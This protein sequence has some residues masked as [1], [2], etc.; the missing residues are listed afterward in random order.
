[1]GFVGLT[2]LLVLATLQDGTSKDPVRGLVKALGSDSIQ[3]R[4]FAA[5]MLRALGAK[6]LP[7]LREGLKDADP[8][9]KGRAKALLGEIE[10]GVLAD[11]RRNKWLDEIAPSLKR[12]SLRF[13]GVSHVEAVRK[14]FGPFGVRAEVNE[15]AGDLGISTVSLRLEKASFWEAFDA[16]CD[17]G[18]VRVHSIHFPFPNYPEGKAEEWTFVA[19]FGRRSPYRW[20]TLGDARV[21]AGPA[22]MG[23][24]GAN[25]GELTVWLAVAFPPTS[26]PEWASIEKVS[27]AGVPIRR[28]DRLRGRVR[29]KKLSQKPGCVTAVSVWRGRDTIRRVALKGAETMSVRGTLILT[30][31]SKSKP[32]EERIPFRIDGIPVPPIPRLPK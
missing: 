26:V 31:S 2:A 4:D 15:S 32:K 5:R 16:Y 25:H 14:I 20:D 21:I 7:A 29:R 3:K 23:D 13:S 19:R 12:V 17:S 1:M 9:V 18:D 27:L 10:P 11:I 22:V 24:G 6:A 8:E 28:E 30:H